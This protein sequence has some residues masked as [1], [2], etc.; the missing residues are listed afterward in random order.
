MRFH[1]N[2]KLGLAGRREL[3]LQIAGGS[4]LREA[5]QAFNVSVATLTAGRSAGGRR[6]RPS[7]GA[8]PAYSIA[9]AGPLAA[10]DGSHPRQSGRSATVAARR[11]GGHGSFPAR[12]ASATRP[13]GRC[14]VEPG[15]HG[16]RVQRASPPTA[17][18]GPAQAICCTWTQA[19]THVFSV[20]ATHSLAT[21]Q[22]KT[23]T[24]VTGSTSCTRS[25]TTTHDLPTPRSTTTN[26]PRPSPASS[27]VPLP[28]TKDTAS[29]PS[30]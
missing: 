7:K 21:A 14:F 16:R 28:S 8:S 9:R 23:A 1:R 2:A 20:P 29:P 3:V 4:S 19:S 18:S 27:S 17:T 22:A 26:K 12:P 11:A 24:T 13:S 25:S 5:A 10:R 15:S 30:V 6:V